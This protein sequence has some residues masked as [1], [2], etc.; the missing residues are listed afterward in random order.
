MINN[1]KTGIN[2]N[3]HVDDLTLFSFGTALREGRATR[4]VRAFVGV[5]SWD[6]MLGRAL[7]FSLPRVSVEN[8]VVSESSDEVCSGMKEGGLIEI[9]C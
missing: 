9:L 2:E 6:G 4:P 7:L 3:T 8:N 1:T 5:G